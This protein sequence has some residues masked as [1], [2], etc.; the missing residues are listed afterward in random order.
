MAGG[1]LGCSTCQLPLKVCTKSGSVDTKYI[2]QKIRKGRCEA[3]LGETSCQGTVAGLRLTTEAASL[4][5][6]VGKL[7]KEILST[8]QGQLST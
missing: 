3:K 2:N 4:T 1:Q 8:R 6:K 7:V 5:R